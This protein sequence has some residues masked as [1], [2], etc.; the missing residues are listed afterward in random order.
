MPVPS[1]KDAVERNL[2]RVFVQEPLQQP[3]MSQT[4]AVG[5]KPPCM[6]VSKQPQDS[7]KSNGNYEQAWYILFLTSDENFPVKSGRNKTVLFMRASVCKWC[8]QPDKL[9]VFFV[10]TSTQILIH[11]QAS[12]YI[13][14][15][16][17]V[18]EVPWFLKFC[19]LSFGTIRKSNQHLCKQTRKAN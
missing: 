16:P 9:Y 10:N 17:K 5:C 3:F 19:F 8:L 12:F 11:L 14:L 6:R 1:G 2:R 7:P 18:V 4:V 13:C 15:P